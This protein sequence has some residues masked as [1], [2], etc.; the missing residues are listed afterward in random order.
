MNLEENKDIPDGNQSQ[1]IFDN[2]NFFDDPVIPDLNDQQPIQKPPLQPP[3][4]SQNIN[5]DDQNISEAKEKRILT[6]IVV[7]MTI[8]FSVA[9]L[10]SNPQNRDAVFSYL[11]KND[12]V[13][14]IFGFDSG[15]DSDELT[16]NDNINNHTEV[17]NDTTNTNNSA[18]IS[19]TSNTDIADNTDTDNTDVSNESSKENK[20][21]SG[22]LFSFEYPSSWTIQD[23]SS[24]LG[25]VRIMSSD[26]D[27]G[28]NGSGIA[29]ISGSDIMIN[30]DSYIHDIEEYITTNQK[31]GTIENVSEI[32][33]D[34]Q[35][36][37]KYKA[38]D[39]YF[40]SYHAIFKK[41]NISYDID[42]ATIDNANLDVFETVI[43][44]LVVN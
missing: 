13:S 42:F 37:Y 1:N 14:K 31:N 30:S 40:D 16:N 36:S 27:Y 5:I 12:L 41:N 24:N 11:R 39:V 18:D 25:K 20:T 33:I 19:N 10:A 9:F 17:E 6:V 21:Y 15:T 7:V 22:S 34:G 4:Q 44:T 3:Y 29:M 28:E 38:R 23:Y 2:Q 35:K 8:A 43:S 32:K 26:L